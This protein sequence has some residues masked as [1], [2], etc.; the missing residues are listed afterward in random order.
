MN[1]ILSNLYIE[2]NFKSILFYQ[3]VIGYAFIG[4][5]CQQQDE[6]R[7][8]IGIIKK[9]Q[10][11][12]K[13]D[14]P[15][16]VQLQ[17]PVPLNEFRIN[18]YLSVNENKI[19][20][21]SSKQ[22]QGK[23][24][25]IP[26]SD[27]IYFK[28][29]RGDVIA[30]S[31]CLISIKNQQNL[32]VQQLIDESIKFDWKRIPSLQINE[33]M[34]YL[35]LKQI[36]GDIAYQF[37]IQDFVL[38]VG[39][40]KLIKY[41]YKQNVVQELDIED[42]MKKLSYLSV[43]QLPNLCF[44]ISGGVDLEQQIIYPNSYLYNPHQNQINVIAS[45]QQKRF[46]HSSCY[47][48][49][50]IFVTGGRIYG[51]DQQS[52]LKSC[53]LYD[54]SL[55]KWQLIPQLNRPRFSHGMLQVK[56]KIYVFG[57]NDGN[58]NLSS[59]EIFNQ[60]KQEWDL[61]ILE[62]NSLNIRDPYLIA[63]DNQSVII[64]SMYYDDDE[65]EGEVEDD[66]NMY[67]NQKEY[68]QSIWKIDLQNYKCQEIG[69]FEIQEN[70]KN[71][72]YFNIYEK[73][74]NILVDSNKQ[75]FIQTIPD[76]KI[77]NTKSIKQPQE[78]NG[79]SL[80]RYATSQRYFQMDAGAQNVYQIEICRDTLKIFDENKSELLKYLKLNQI[81]DGITQ[82]LE[83]VD[84]KILVVTSL[85]QK[86]KRCYII[87]VNNGLCYST[88][89]MH[90]FSEIHSF[91]FN[92]L[93]GLLFYFSENVCQYY[94]QFTNEWKII[95][96]IFKVSNIN[97]QL[98]K[99]AS[100]DCRN[101]D[102]II[103]I[104]L[105]FSYLL[106]FNVLEFKIYVVIQIQEDCS[107]QIE[108]PSQHLISQFTVQSSEEFLCLLEK[109]GFNK[110]N[111]MQNKD[112]QKNTIQKSNDKTSNQC[113]QISRFYLKDQETLLNDFQINIKDI[114]NFDDSYYVFVI[115]ELG[116]YKILVYSVSCQY[117][118]LLKINQQKH[119][120][121]QL[122]NSNSDDLFKDIK[123][124]SPCFYRQCKCIHI[125][126]EKILLVGG[127]DE[128]S[129]TGN[130]VKKTIIYDA[131]SQLFSFV[132]D[133]NQPR[134][135]HQLVVQNNCI[136]AIAGRAN[137]HQNTALQTVEK[138]N[139]F[140]DKWEFI[141]P[142][143]QPRYNFAACN[144][145]QKIYISGGTHNKEL[146]DSIEVL[147][148][149]DWRVLPVKLPQRMEGLS[150]IAQ[151]FYEIIILGGQKIKKSKQIYILNVNDFSLYESRQKLNTG[152]SHFHAFNYKNKI[153]LFGGKYN[154]E[155]DIEKITCNF[156]SNQENSV[157]QIYSQSAIQKNSDT[158][159]LYGD[160]L[161]CDLSEFGGSLANGNCIN[162][163]FSPL[164]KESAFLIVFGE[165]G[166]NYLNLKSLELNHKQPIS[167]SGNI[168]QNYK[169]AK[170]S[171]ACNIFDGKVFISG[172]LSQN[173]N[174]I[175]NDCFI[176]STVTNTIEKVNSMYES[177]FYHCSIYSTNFVYVFAGRGYNN[178]QQQD[179]VNQSFK[180]S[181][182]DLT[183]VLDRCEK[184]NLKTYQWE[185]LPRLNFARQLSVATVYQNKV[186]I[187]GGSNEKIK[188][189]QIERLNE[190]VGRWEI[191]SFCLIEGVDSFSSFWI[192]DQ[193]FIILGGEYDQF[194]L[195]N[196][197]D[198]KF[199]NSKLKEGSKKEQ[200]NEQHQSYNLSTAILKMQIVN[201][202]KELTTLEFPQF[203]IQQSGNYRNN[204]ISSDSEQFIETF[205][206]I[207]YYAQPSF[208]KVAYYDQ[209][210][211]LV[212]ENQGF[213]LQADQ[214]EHNNQ[215]GQHKLLVK[216]II[217]PPCYFLIPQL[218]DEK[219]DFTPYPYTQNN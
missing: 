65:S 7:T 16:L 51:D 131:N 9:D 124:Q 93:T 67:L 27:A 108:I 73:Q 64:I 148:G 90:D 46:Y 203:Q 13:L 43:T 34:F 196:K 114:Q 152:R 184:F 168:I 95:Q 32:N 158:N 140:E 216:M 96:N 92:K 33:E 106:S 12:C 56:G 127:I 29:V 115:T 138:Y 100:F 134:I 89:Q 194:C 167:L 185:T 191:I 71:I 76:M 17:N 164:L 81:F 193:E 61:V 69:Q 57:G 199:I 123:N 207:I 66:Q 83:L 10:R 163:T 212:L 20:Q 101:S 107:N 4:I 3:D 189:Q 54:F 182:S 142:I 208:F 113:Y 198:Y 6:L 151:N 99:I 80:M 21:V 205:K 11:N 201:F 172:G 38:L 219:E 122:K 105:N 70:G 53:E 49:N 79:K 59:L 190:N 169:T 30:E 84:G 145:N 141:S 132:Q 5:Q 86:E 165:Y 97:K 135:N 47:F 177:R 36:Q 98:D 160:I 102:Q 120:N 210:L 149:Q 173:N 58:G 14:S 147:E 88:S 146:L 41:Y 133:M 153:L 195:K 197:E 94:S 166:I 40:G 217:K 130:A 75:I 155:F 186:Y 110:I 128:K 118:S 179:D 60:S 157:S 143:N 175:V 22:I 42:Q 104:L 162:N 78:F 188:V 103:F 82:I 68:H 192:S 209:S 109:Q 74:I 129:I 213:S 144:V 116:E 218:I 15:I 112:E 215:N 214:K 85:S 24:L 159:I 139:Y 52:V 31:L 121:Y 187:I 206:N 180:E 126:N 2:F 161:K 26:F 181:G 119:D 156:R 62:S 204:S 176:Y 35:N 19:F 48:Q 200:T 125:R 72:I 150:M 136:L 87:D 171:H 1:S 63:E 111:C 39:E 18:L 8:Q 25:N 23:Y 174:Q 154:L 37:E 170:Y 28:N 77:I 202:Q 45:M 183:T 44:F 91:H 117:F 211:L 137:L 50:Q 178:M 55:K